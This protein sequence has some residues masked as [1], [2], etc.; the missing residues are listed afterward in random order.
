LPSHEEH[1]Q[2]TFKRYAVR[3]DDIHH[4]MDEPSKAFGKGHREYRHDSNTVKLVGRVFG[5][6]YGVELAENIALD[7]IM[8]DHE[9]EIRNRQ[10][11][12]NNF[13]RQ[14][15]SNNMYFSTNTKPILIRRRS[16]I[17]N[18]ALFFSVTIFLPMMI[19]YAFFSDLSN[20]GWIG[21][22]FFLLFW[23]F[24]GCGLGSSSQSS[25]RALA[26]FLGLFVFLPLGVICLFLFWVNYTEVGALTSGKGPE[27]S[28]FFYLFIFSILFC[29][30]CAAKK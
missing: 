17:Q 10:E 4:F 2:H 13:N 26:A 29:L 21:F 11:G 8:A 19:Y 24:L 15:S 27:Y 9:E 3:G 25:S 23:L 18:V 14:Y 16:R 22:L 20:S 30:I 1:C 28:V 12:G 7:H 6:K 5:Q